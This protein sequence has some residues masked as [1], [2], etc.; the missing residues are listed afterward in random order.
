MNPRIQRDVSAYYSASLLKHGTSAKGVDWNTEASQILRFKQ[1]IRVIE[2]GTRFS[3]TDVGCGYGAFYPF[4]KTAFNDFHYAGYD[5]SDSMIEAAQKLHPRDENCE[6]TQDPSALRKSDYAVASGIFN[7]RLHYPDDVWQDYV[8]DSLS[9]LDRMS[10]KGF[11]FNML[12]SFSDPAY[13]RADL[14]YADPIYYFRF[15]KEHFSRFVTLYHDYP[16]YEFTISV[17]KDAP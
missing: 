17:K 5:I 6:W 3:I 16:L 1:L 12:T 8:L 2:A 11:S 4:L 7:V 13:R 15:C 10:T 14:Y 9:F